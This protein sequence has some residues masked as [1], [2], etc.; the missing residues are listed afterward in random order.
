V[1]AAVNLPQATAGGRQN[2][3]RHVPPRRVPC[4]SGGNERGDPAGGHSRQCERVSSAAPSALQAGNPAVPGIT[5]KTR[6][7]RLSQ[8]CPSRSQGSKAGEPPEEAR[9]AV[10]E[11]AGR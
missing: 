6:A 8:R 3:G 11:A 5:G 7:R 4:C 1:Q 9:T 10:R 2:A